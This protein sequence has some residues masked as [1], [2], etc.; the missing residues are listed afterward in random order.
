MSTMIW[1]SFIRCFFHIEHDWLITDVALKSRDSQS[2]V[3]APL[4]VRSP[5]LGGFEHIKIVVI[6]EISNSFNM[7]QNEAETKASWNKQ[8]ARDAFFLL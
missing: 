6:V 7:I 8:S 5:P 3:L 2:M 1:F 4:V